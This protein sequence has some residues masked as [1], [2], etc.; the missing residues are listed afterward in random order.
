MGPIK[1]VL[2]EELSNSLRMKKNYERELAKLPIGSLIK[3]KIKGHD[4]HYLVFRKNGK[5]KFVYKGKLSRE[6]IQK[7]DEIKQ[8]RARYRKLLSQVKQQ[9]IFLRRSL[10]GKQSV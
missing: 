7:Y 4:Y 9:I 8:Y 6:E 3:K 10:R 2:K 5:V 1:S